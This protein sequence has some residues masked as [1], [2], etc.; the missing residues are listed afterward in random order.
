LNLLLPVEVQ[1]RELESKLALGIVQASRGHQVWVGQSAILHRLI[2]WLAPGIY[3]GK[4]LTPPFK[5]GPNAWYRRAKKRGWRVI[6]LDEEGAVHP[7][8]ESEWRRIFDLRLNPNWLG[9]DDWICTWGD[10]QRDHYQSQWRGKPDR[11]VTTGHPRFDMA[12]PDWRPFFRVQVE[13][14]NDAYGDFVLVNTNFPIPNHHQGPD[15]VFSEVMGYLK[16]DAT[17]RLAYVRQWGAFSRK[18]AHLIE[19]VHHLKRAHPDLPTIVRPHPSE[20]DALYR[21]TLGRL[22][23]VFVIRQGQVL[24]WVFAARVLI[25]DGCTTA[26]EA[27]LAGTPVITYEAEPDPLSAKL[28]PNAMGIHCHSEK[29]VFEAMAQM[30]TAKAGSDPSVSVAGHAPEDLLW[31]LKAKSWERISEVID[32]A[33]MGLPREGG[34]GEAI[35]IPRRIG[36][37]SSLKRRFN[38]RRRDPTQYRSLKFPSL[39]DDALKDLMKRLMTQLGEEVRWDL[40]G[41]HVV[42]I[43]PARPS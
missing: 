17:H 36:E 38:Q 32:R 22:D 26:L 18:I 15:K 23:G 24:P 5:N 14:L 37:L 33:A 4:D 13:N 20:D 41:E 42:Q 9:D 29:A 31:N 39:N 2:P 11:V 40:C 1:T 3:L 27:Q 34:M 16:N 30:S 10:F 28:L 8:P 25:H 12:K 6:H 21:A 7:G 35:A 43:N 19:L